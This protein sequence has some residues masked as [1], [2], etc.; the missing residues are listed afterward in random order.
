MTFP[1]VVVQT[2]A[3]GLLARVWVDNRTMVVAIDL[4]RNSSA[5]AGHSGHLPVPRKAHFAQT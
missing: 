2:H 4:R 1:L 5:E 3:F